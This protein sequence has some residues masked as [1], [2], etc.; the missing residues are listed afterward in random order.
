M[1]FMAIHGVFVF[2]EVSKK[3][4]AIAPGPPKSATGSMHLKLADVIA[5][6]IEIANALGCIFIF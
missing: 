2:L 5:V 4:G 1:H 6:R 3:E